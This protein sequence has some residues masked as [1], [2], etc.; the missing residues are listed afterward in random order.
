MGAAGATGVT[1]DLTNLSSLLNGGA[2]LDSN[3][4]GAEGIQVDALTPADLADLSAAGITGAEGAQLLTR[5]GGIIGLQSPTGSVF[6]VPV[7]GNLP[8]VGGTTLPALPAN[9]GN[10]ISGLRL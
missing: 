3:L 5:S 9:L 6:G 2:V 1:G 8:I 4:F 7:E 10:T